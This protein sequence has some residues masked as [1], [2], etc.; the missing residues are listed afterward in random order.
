MPTFILMGILQGLK[1]LPSVKPVTP[2]GKEKW[3]V[4]LICLGVFGAVLW[5]EAGALVANYRYGNCEELLGDKQFSAAMTEIEQAVNWSP[6]NAY[7]QAVA[8]N[9][10]YALRRFDEAERFFQ[11]A[12]RAD[13]FRAVYH[14]DLA[15]A[16]MRLER[17]PLQIEAELRRA[18]ALNPM[19]D[20]SDPNR[21]CYRTELEQFE[22]RLRQSSP[23]LLESAPAEER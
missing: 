10:A 15:R 8:G 18:V 22:K 11:A 5:A 19:E 14:W 1:D 17:Q 7:Y 6:K 4:G 21:P 12:I 16:E 3:A 23:P 2:R 9:C 13:P 20:C